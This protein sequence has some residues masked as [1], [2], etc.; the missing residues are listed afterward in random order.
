MAVITG[1]IKQKRNE[2]Y[3]NNN[4]Q[5]SFSIKKVLPLFSDLSYR[6]L[7]VAKG[8]EAI[9]AY[10]KFKDLEAED[11]ASLQKDLIEY[12]KQDTYAMV[13]ILWEL[14]RKVGLLK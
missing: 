2:D 4:L 8:T 3:Y 9:A 11:L 5:G 12:C 14:M 13:L 6:D 10:A 1:L 7:N